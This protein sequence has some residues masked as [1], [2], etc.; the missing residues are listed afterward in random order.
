MKN[1]KLFAYFV[2][3]ACS[4]FCNFPDQNDVSQDT[5]S[6]KKPIKKVVYTCICG[7]YDSLISHSYVRDGWDYVC[8][9]DNQE[10]LKTGHSQWTI[11]PLAYE[12]RDNTRTNRW[13][14]MFPHKILEEYDISLYIDGNIDINNS[15]LFDFVDVEL[16]EDKSKSLVINKHY[17]RNCIYQEARVCRKAQL[18]MASII[19]AQM[20]IYKH[21]NYPK[22]NGLTENFMIYRRHHE[23]EVKAVM[24]DWWYWV[25]NY[26][27]R[28]QLSFNFVIWNRGFKIDLFES[29]FARDGSCLTFIDHQKNNRLKQDLFGT[30]FFVETAVISASFP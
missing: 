13:H 26:S 17:I 30:A 12:G 10:W 22:R 20:L 15:E 23:P 8:F 19:N 3:F 5:L 16:V 24:E 27:R 2:L 25:L 9:T 11:L 28:D 6:L 18:D 7:N 1:W 21:L 29:R 14:K 4:G